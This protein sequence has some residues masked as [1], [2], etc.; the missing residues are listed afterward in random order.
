METDQKKE[1]RTFF[2]NLTIDYGNTKLF[3]TEFGCLTALIYATTAVF[4]LS[5]FRKHG[6]GNQIR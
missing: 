1:I 5:S 4:I 2:D 6:L 3:T